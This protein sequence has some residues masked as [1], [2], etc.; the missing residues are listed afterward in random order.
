MTLTI[1]LQHD[2]HPARDFKNIS[3]LNV[4]VLQHK[5]GFRMEKSL[6]RFHKAK[7]EYIEF[8]KD[9]QHQAS[10]VENSRIQEIWSPEEGKFR[11]S[12]IVRDFALTS[13]IEWTSFFAIFV[14]WILTSGELGRHHT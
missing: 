8:H 10:L 11:V 5:L 12:G 7:L 2:P 3:S 4:A 9:L 6:E 14:Y 13:L 1:S